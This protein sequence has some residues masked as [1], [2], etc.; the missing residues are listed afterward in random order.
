MKITT[1]K[2]SLVTTA[3]AFAFNSAFAG[4][5]T[6]VPFTQ[7]EAT[8]VSGAND[9]FTDQLFLFTTGFSWVNGYTN[10]VAQTINYTTNSGNGVLN[11]LAFREN[12]DIKLAG[13]EVGDLYDFVY[14][15]SSDG[16]L[17]FGT[18]IVLESDDDDDLAVASADDDDDEF[19]VELNFIYRSGF[20]N[21][22][23][24]AAWTYQTSNDLRMYNAA[25]T[26]SYE[27]EGPFDAN[28]D[29]IRF[30]ADISPE[31]GNPISGLYLVKTDATTFSVV[32]N[33]IGYYQAG[34]EGQP[35]VGEFLAGYAPAA[36]VP[37]AETYAMML[38][39][40]AMIGTIARRRKSA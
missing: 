17:V 16:K 23:T 5:F 9:P 7:P 38:A 40:L 22:S 37:E 3:L 36:A 21:Y 15:D 8:V 11:L 29:L 28:A 25:R 18:R 31:E 4:N 6:D 10:L 27:L 33:A 30:Q 14:Q 2:Q 20:T 1:L 35:I 26:D 19:E 13:H 39:G 32:A 34:E 24:A 12:D